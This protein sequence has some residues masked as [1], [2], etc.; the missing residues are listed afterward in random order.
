[1]LTFLAVAA[2]K[3]FV[4]DAYDDCAVGTISKNERGRL[5]VSR[6]SLRP[7]IQFA[8]DHQPTYEQ[9]ARM[10]ELAHA[11]CFIANSVQTEVVVEAPAQTS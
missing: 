10:H 4:V 3:R 9:L 1:M 6:V 8:G 7:V 11:N 2:R 5:W